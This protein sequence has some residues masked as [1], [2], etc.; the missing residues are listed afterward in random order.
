VG[1]SVRLD[2]SR[3][4]E[5]PDREGMNIGELF[6]DHIEVGL[7]VCGGVGYWKDIGACTLCCMPVAVVLKSSDI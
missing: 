1:A 7:I 5:P 4:I 2:S 6:G 3:G